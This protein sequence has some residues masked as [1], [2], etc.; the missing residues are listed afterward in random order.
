MPKPN[1]IIVIPM[2][3]LSQRFKNAG[4][5]EPKFKLRLAGKSV[6][7]Y[8]VGSFEAYF[9]TNPFLFV[10]RE[11]E[12]LDRFLIAE[13]ET[14]G[15]QMPILVGLAAPTRGQADTVVQGLNITQIDD[16]QP[17]IIF[18]IDTFRPGYRLPEHFDLAR[19]DGYL[20]VFRGSGPNWSYVRPMDA[21]DCRAA[22][23]SE[24]FEISDLCCTGLYYFREISRFK[25]AF[26]KQVTDDEIG[27]L[28]VA[29]LYNHLI[30]AGADI[31][32]HE[33]NPNAL[34]FCGVPEEYELLQENWEVGSG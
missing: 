22:E 11:E 28:Y 4:Y 32:Y 23:T 18:N 3:G 30:T 6:F 12:G 13:C 7:R 24:K 19:I 29:P 33:I 16:S 5:A 20:E 15:V 21:D 26:E 10:Y 17:I 31:R 14:M 8:A 9:K 1:M 25:E 2:A 34:T 27:E